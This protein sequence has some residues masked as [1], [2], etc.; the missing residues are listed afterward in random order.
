LEQLS[1]FSRRT[2]YGANLRDSSTVSGKSIIIVAT[3]VCTSY[4]VEMLKLKMRIGHYNLAYG[5]YVV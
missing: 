3:I 4:R 2:Y 1:V 5:M